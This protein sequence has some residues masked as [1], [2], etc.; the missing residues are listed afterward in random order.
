[1]IKKI[2]TSLIFLFCLSLLPEGSCSPF[3]IQQT[4]ITISGHV[5]DS[6]NGE[7]LAGVTIF[8]NTLKTGTSTIPDF[9][10]P[11]SLL[12]RLKGRLR[13]EIGRLTGRSTL[14]ES[15]CAVQPVS[16]LESL[17]FPET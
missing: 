1:M 16:S 17:S 8:E 6:D 13:R 15:L 7:V 2:F 10:P 12:E 9:H 11:E 5:T 14:K 4:K 3:I